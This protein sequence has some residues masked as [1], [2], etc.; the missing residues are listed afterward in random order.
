LGLPINPD[1]DRDWW[2]LHTSVEFAHLS[3]DWLQTQLS[4][5]NWPEDRLPVRTRDG[6][7]VS[8]NCVAM[9]YPVFK[10]AADRMQNGGRLGDEGT[11]DSMNPWI[12]PNFRVA[13]LSF[14][15]Q[16]KGMTE[17]ELDAIRNTYKEES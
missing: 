7:A 16:E 9:K 4:G 1:N 13:H 11:I 17:D 8:I 5:F 12:I 2:A 14:G 15:S 6:E 10:Q 3:H